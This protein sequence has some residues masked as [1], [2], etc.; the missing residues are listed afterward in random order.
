M[1][2][3]WD[4]DGLDEDDFVEG[5]D[6]EDEELGVDYHTSP[7]EDDEPATPLG[8][9]H[10]PARPPVR[11][12]RPERMRKQRVRGGGRKFRIR[13]MSDRMAARSPGVMSI[14]ITK[15]DGSQVLLV[16]KG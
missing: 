3:P 2:D 10:K 1:N 4:Q 6:D 15:A 8:H 12:H 5:I 7:V 14:L 11:K 13:R 16:R 9:E